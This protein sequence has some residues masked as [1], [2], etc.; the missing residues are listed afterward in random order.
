MMVTY[1][2]NGI[3]R[4]ISIA[5][6]ELVRQWNFDRHI[7]AMAG[8]FNADEYLFVIG[9]ENSLIFTRRT[10]KSEIERVECTIKGTPSDIKFSKNRVHLIVICEEGW[11]YAYYS[12]SDSH[13]KS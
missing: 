5:G 13:W 10:L 6:K 12:H 11:V 9:S 7:D 1:S 3:V 8:L 2:E 4:V